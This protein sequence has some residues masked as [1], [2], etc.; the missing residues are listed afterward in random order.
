M[1]TRIESGHVYTETLITK[2]S[3]EAEAY[4]LDKL[5]HLPTLK[6]FQAHDI[7]PDEIMEGPQPGNV[8]LTAGV[9]QLWR[10]LATTD[11][12]WDSTHGAIGVGTDTTSGVNTQ[13]VL[14]GGSKYY[15]AWS[16][17]P[18]VGTGGAST[19]TAVFSST[20]GTAVA[21][22][23]W[24][25][26][27]VVIPLTGGTTAYSDGTSQQASYILLNR[28]GGSGLLGTKTSAQSWAFSVTM[29]LA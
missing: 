28:K 16:A 6:D 20:F 24:N 17:A 7:T 14:L 10:R 18:T 8:L 5:G 27:G 29:T 22:F 26:Y 4:L 13:T 25:E 21:N 1:T 9:N 19:I 12:I 23:A 3:A 15:K 11:Q 2:Y